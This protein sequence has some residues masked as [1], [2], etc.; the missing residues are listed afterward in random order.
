MTGEH[1]EQVLALIDNVRARWRRLA[2]LRAMVR[3]GL[4]TAA[5][6]AIGLVGAR[7]ASGSAVALLL[8]AAVIGLAEVVALVRLLKPVLESPADGRVARFVE[9]RE[10]GLD[11]QLV[12]AVALLKD[13]G[14]ES[15]AFAGPLLADAARRASAVDPAAIV[16]EAA[17]RRARGEALAAAVCV[18]L[19]AVAG[20]DTWRGMFSALSPG[21]FGAGPVLEVTP[22]DIRLRAGEALAIEARVEGRPAGT[23]RL[24]YLTGETPDLAG[25]DV[26]EADWASSE[27][28]ALSAGAFAFSFESVHAPF[29]YRVEADGLRSPVYQVSVTRVPR[30]TSIDVDYVFPPALGLEPRTETDGGDIYAPAGTSVRLRVHTDVPAPGGRLS[31][32]DGSAIELGP[33]GEVLSGALTVEADASYRVALTDEA[34][35]TDP[36][37]T[38]Y[39]IRILNDRPPEIRVRRPARDRDVTPLEEVDVEAEAHDDFGLERLELVYSVGG[40]PE[41]AVPFPIAPGAKAASATHTMFLEDLDVRPGD[42]VSYYVRAR[43]VARGA[44]TSEARSDIFFLQV[45]PFGQEFTLVDGAGLGGGA[46]RSLGDLVTAQ[47]QIIVATWKLDRRSDAAG[48]T[49]ERD[50]RAVARA[51][52]DL[53]TR[54]EETASSFRTSTLRDPR[55]GTTTGPQ[56]GGRAGGARAEE[57]AM[58]A[59]AA[60]MGRAV[61]SLES[62]RT[63]AALP[64]EMEALNALLEAQDHLKRQEVPRQQE[65]RGGNNRTA[66]D[67]SGLFDE[68]LQREQQTNVEM[69]PPPEEREDARDDTIDR[70][71]ELARRQEGLVRRQQQLDQDQAQMTEEKLQAELDRLSSEQSALGE[72]ADE[73]AKQMAGGEQ[74]QQQ[75]EGGQSGSQSQPGQQSGGQSGQSSQQ[76]SSGTQ[77]QAGQQGQMAAQPSESGLRQMQA[78]SSEMRGAASELSRRDA[79][80]AAE[81]GARALEH[82]RQY[83]DELRSASPDEQRRAL[84][85]MQLE[86][87]QLADAQRQLGSDLRAAATGE[88]LKDAMR[89]LAGEQDRLAE[90]AERLEEDLARQGRDSQTPTDAPEAAEDLQRAAGEAARELDRQR[91]AERMAQSAEQLR[92]GGRGGETPSAG[93]RAST[94]R[95]QEE[96]ARSLERLADQL[97]SATSAGDQETERLTGQLARAE[98]LRERIEQATRQLERLDQE[99][100]GGDSPSSQGPP[101]PTGAGSSLEKVREEL[102]QQLQQARALLDEVQ[103]EDPEFTPGAGAGATLEGQ[104]MVFSAPGTESFKQDFERWETLRA[105]TTEALERVGVSVSSRMNARASRERLAAGVDDRVPAEYQDHVDSYFKALA[106]KKSP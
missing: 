31:L 81:R 55:A 104:G 99:A 10:P 18:L 79:G 37:D 59:A 24:M 5:L 28:T 91:I 36:G 98:E 84:G 80:Q 62:L 101:G 35:R 82:L 77:G 51:E 6:L 27:M 49:S 41:R 26:A 30:V 102:Q 9:E 23:P 76:G 53:K 89:R 47:K 3:A 92:E 13:P 14:A 2:R 63:A 88:A 50:I 56:S 106:G 21:V 38:E 52:A 69:P 97:A 78:I 39:F 75:S 57:V 33:E 70:V 96:V 83:E 73:M 54:V 103:R 11:D 72:R 60:A 42:F 25:G 20:R 90:R 85:D 4:A 58:A 22:G 100:R 66:A 1:H 64:A 45:R 32:S 17:L 95:A 61:A 86:A 44:R 94:A 34:G 8:V 29:R 46:D 65:G 7:L 48:A 12:S 19:V 16:P 40:G 74:Q 15:G 67:L 105:Q 68:E 87:R 71:R 43:D 93:E